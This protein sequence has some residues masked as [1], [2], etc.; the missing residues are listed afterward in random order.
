MH[1]G[2]GNACHHRTRWWFHSRKTCLIFGILLW[3]LATGGCQKR[4]CIVPRKQELRLNF[5]RPPR[6]LDPRKSTEPIT[7][8][9]HLMLYAGL[10]HLEED[11]TLSCALA[12]NVS[13]SNHGK[14]YLFELRPS[15]WSNGEPV[16]AYDFEHSWK[17]SVDPEFSSSASFLYF[18]LKNGE[19]IK[20]GRSSIDTLGVHAI[21]AHTL[22]VEL[23]RPVPYFL[24]LIAHPV[25]FPVPYQNQ[26]GH[27]LKRGEKFITNGPFSLLSWKR[28]REIILGKNP[29]YWKRDQVRLERIHISLVQDETTALFLFE[30]GKIDWLGGLLSPLPL[31]SIPTLREKGQIHQSPMVGTTFFVFNLTHF[32]LHNQHIRKAFAYAI[33]R[34]LLIDHVTLLCDE[35]AT[36][37]IPSILRGE[38]P[39]SLLLDYHEERAR[40]HFERGLK[41]LGI[42]R[43]EF[44][45]LSYHFFASEINRKLAIALQAQWKKVLNIR[46]E[47]TCHE[48]T[49]HLH[50]LRQR[51]FSLA[52]MSW[53]S[54][55]FDPMG[56][57][58]RLYSQKNRLNYSSWENEIFKQLIDQ[59]HLCQRT[60]RKKWLMEAEAI[61]IEELP[62]VPL[63]H[64]Q[65]TYVQSPLLK[66]VKISPLG[67]TQ[68]QSA[69]M[70]STT[71]HS[72]KEERRT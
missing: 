70:D 49:T 43:K 3:G 6:S 54:P 29:Y 22:I 20:R 69:Y 30:Q 60:E 46:V 63:Y 18:V 66:Q 21:N 65:A 12:H 62:F 48:F 33:D 23:E 59:S 31:E 27:H 36:G 8:T 39:S 41:E 13:T 51:T 10:M 35:K 68:F 17:R 19:D 15:F 32:P 52:Q 58:E 1:K 40:D 64:Y 72:E 16:T 28:D 67:Y 55:Y 56:Y 45:I 7:C 57:L 2:V 34:Q 44:P 26:R 4:E 25:F 24:H 42:V 50:R 14:T 5:S 11:G 71:S 53:V 38:T 47:P 9:T 61:F 37:L